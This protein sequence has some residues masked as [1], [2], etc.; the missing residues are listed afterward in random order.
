MID[1]IRTHFAFII[2][3]FSW[4]AVAAFGQGLIYAW[5]PITILFLKA[6]DYWPELLIGLLIFLVLSDMDKNIRP[7]FIIK[8]AKNIFIVLLAAL[9]ILERGRFAPY[10]RVFNIFLPF[11][12][13]SF[14]PLIWSKVMFLGVQKTL[15]YALMFLI[16]PNYVLYNFRLMGWQFFRSLLQ[17][18]AF[19]VVMGL[20]MHYVGDIETEIGGRFRGLFG[21]PNGLAIYCFLCILL[22]SV[23]IAINKELF[24]WKERVVL[25]GIFFYFLIISGSRTSLA[26]TMIFL[27]FHRFFSY[28][29]FL[30][31]VLLL[32]MFG[33]AEVISA[34]LESIILSFGLE[35]YF[36]LKTLEDGSG[37][38]F[39]WEFTWGHIQ[40]FFIFGGGFANDEAIMKYH[41]LYLERM[42][43]QGGV[44]NTYLSL[45]LNVGIIG[46]AIYLRSLFLLF[47]KAS[48]LVPMSLAVMFAV[49]FSVMYESWLVGSLN[50]FTIILLIIMTA[51]S[52]E[53]IADWRSY[54]GAAEPVEEEE[55]LVH[56]TPNPR[57]GI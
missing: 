46:L 2:I 56:Y 10:S 47:F 21:N 41:R 13:Y 34:N 25:Y 3:A 1:F 7:M 50:P 53:E 57:L 4:V 39:A 30:G 27:V 26:S 37:R 14:F 54:E 51:L 6:R 17:F 33:I 44:H 31:F 29:P 24:S 23:V 19:I 38:Y 36:R 11:F 43:H 48:K 28:S 20:V 55:Q 22:L 35:D 15:S 49:L 42:G 40:N 52:E 12:I 8:G 32:G 9:F 18:M 5:L 45:W 16:I